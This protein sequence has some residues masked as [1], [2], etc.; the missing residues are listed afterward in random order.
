MTPGQARVNS[1]Q[2]MQLGGVAQESHHVEGVAAHRSVGAQADIEPLGQHV[3]NG[4]D[5]LARL[6]IGDDV[7]A[8]ADAVLPEQGVKRAGLERERGEGD[9]GCCGPNVG[10]IGVRKGFVP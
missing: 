7:V 10:E 5:S 6:D 3:E 1:V 4:S 9:G 2:L 8:H